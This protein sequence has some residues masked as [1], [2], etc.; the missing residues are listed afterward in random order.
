MLIKEEDEGQEMFIGQCKEG[1]FTVKVSVHMSET[2]QQE[3]LLEN[4]P[5]FL[6]EDP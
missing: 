6:R 4:L 2:L 1:L 3:T 5:G